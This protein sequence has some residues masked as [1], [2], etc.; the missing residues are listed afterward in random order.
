MSPLLLACLAYLSVAVPGSSLGLLW[1]SMRLS[2][3]APTGVLIL[4]RCG[5]QA[6]VAPVD[7]PAASQR[8]FA[9]GR[10][11]SVVAVVSVLTFVAVETG[12][13]SGAGVW[14]TSS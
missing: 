14:A 4:G 12:V 10:R 2:F 7:P 8:P 1:P 6:A 11:P 5:W 13:E 9:A 3:G